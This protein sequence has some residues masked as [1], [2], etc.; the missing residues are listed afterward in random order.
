MCHSAGFPV[1]IG[2]SGM[3]SRF[4]QGRLEPE[5][6]SYCKRSCAIVEQFHIA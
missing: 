1:G 6:S 3:T 4:A 5:R 2:E